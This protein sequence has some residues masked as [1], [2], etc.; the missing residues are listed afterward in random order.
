MALGQG[1]Y[2]WRN[3]KVLQQIGEQVQL[4][5]EIRTNGTLRS[6]RWSRGI[7]LVAEGKT[8]EREEE[9]KLK[10]AEG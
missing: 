2:R 5:C 10:R 1:R 8:G 3:E 4:H 9:S 7:E 6:A